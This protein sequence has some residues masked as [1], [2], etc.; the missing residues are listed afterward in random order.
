MICCCERE[1]KC[2]FIAIFT[3][4]GC[5]GLETSISY[6]FSMATWLF[7]FIQDENINRLKLSKSSFRQIF[8]FAKILKI[9]LSSNMFHVFSTRILIK[10]GPI[11]MKLW[12]LVKKTNIKRSMIR[13]SSLLFN[14]RKR[15]FFLCYPLFP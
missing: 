8:I 6:N 15:D 5:W 11:H 14:V 7:P 10:N 1:L 12:C 4:G 2:S 9:F 3:S 13:T